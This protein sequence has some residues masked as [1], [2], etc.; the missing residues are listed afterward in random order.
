MGGFGLSS[1]LSYETA[2]KILLFGDGAWATDSLVPLQADERFRVSAV[3]QRIEPSEE[4]LGSVAR[5]LNIPVVQPRNVNSE[6]FLRQVQVLS[7][8]LCL[9]ISYNQILKTGLLQ[10]APLGTINFHAG[11]LPYYRGRNVIIW[12]IINGETE[13]GLTSHF[14]DEGI[15]TGDIIHQE[16]LPI[17]WTDTY[18]EVL[19]RIVK[20]FPGFVMRTVGSV[21]SGNYER[22]SQRDAAG[23]YFG[24][25][26][27]GD[28]WLDWSDTSFNIHNKI[29]AIA[30]P[31]PGARTMMGTEPLIVW[32]AFFDPA[33]PKYLATPG[34]VVGRNSG[35]VLVKTGDSTILVQE[36][37]FSNSNCLTPQWP[38]GTRLGINAASQL[39]AVLSRL[40][41]LGLA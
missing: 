6:D 14:V 30:H 11:K 39:T 41:S 9:S 3:V 15:D 27:A 28:E 4:T 7:P 13:I 40:H 10:A 17:E 38:I 36:V 37:Q 24:A 33:S 32:K 8:D 19:A 2:L 18:G 23:T 25:R 5:E 22:R 29:R 12:A 21:A 20:R 34:R 1:S 26:E 35:G 16:L 31:G